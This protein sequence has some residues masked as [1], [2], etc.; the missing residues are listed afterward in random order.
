MYVIVDEQDM[1]D[2][3]FLQWV[4]MTIGTFFIFTFF[5]IFSTSYLTNSASFAEHNEMIT[6]LYQ[7]HIHTNWE[8][9]IYLWERQATGLFWFNIGSVVFVST[10]ILLTGSASDR[11]YA[12]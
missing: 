5:S 12:I 9:I 10:V 3:G 1:G 6:E 2:V 4:A 7:H 11:K 8:L